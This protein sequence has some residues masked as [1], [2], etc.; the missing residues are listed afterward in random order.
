[1][2]MVISSAVASA[3]SSAGTSNNPLIIWDALDGGS[4]TWSTDTGTEVNDAAY[5]GTGTT[6]DHW[7]AT[8]NGSNQV[9]LMLDFG[10]AQS[11]SFVG[12]ASHNLSDIGASV[13]IDSSNAGTAGT[14]TPR[15]GTTTP[16]DNQAIGFYFSSVSARYWRVWITNATDDVS[17]A[18]AVFGTPITLEQRIYANYVPPIT[19][20]NVELQ[21]N[22]SEGGHLLGASVT[23]QGSSAQASL[24]HIDPATLRGA[25]WKA[26]QQHFNNGGGMFWAWRPTK[27]G[28]LYY[29][30]R[31]GGPIVPKNMGVNE[32][33]QFDMAM[34]F[35]DDT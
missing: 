29:A 22:V 11:V 35:Y 23:R 17:I 12:I 9:A 34:R 8:P 20:T 4:G 28:D 21:S 19:P 7:Q 25:T 26:F 16:S 2:T 31:D 27:Y 15:S 33:M 30:W 24:A 5:A 32:L 6:F 18:V 13:K 1:M 14:W 10:S 3:L